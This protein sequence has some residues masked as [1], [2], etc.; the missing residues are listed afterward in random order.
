LIK[1]FI[2][3]ADEKFIVIFVFIEVD[4]HDPIFSRA[5]IQ[6]EC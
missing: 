6:N 4:I 1:L 5:K 2:E 3:L